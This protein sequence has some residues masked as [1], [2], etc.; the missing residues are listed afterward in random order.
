MQFRKIALASLAVAMLACSD[1]SVAPDSASTN[2]GSGKGAGGPTSAAVAT[3][4]V[5]PSSSSIVLGQT[6]Q[7]AATDADTKGNVVSGQTNVW[8]SSNAGVATVSSAGLVTA[9]AAGTATITAT[10]GSVSGS[11]TVTVA[12]AAAA[13]TPTVA[14]VT[15]APSSSSML[16]G[17]AVQ[18]AATDHD[19][20]GNVLS[21]QTNTWQSS[22]AAVAT[23][24]ATGLVTAVAA[25][26]ATI[27]ATDGAVSGSATVNVSAPATPSSSS[28]Y[29]HQ[30]AGFTLFTE[31]AFNSKAATGTDVTGA[32]GWNAN[33]EF[34]YPLFTIAQDAT[35]PKSASNVGQM[36]FPAGYSGGYSPGYAEKYFPSG[37]SK[38]YMSLW[39]KLSSN[40]YG[41][42]TYVNK[43]LYLWIGGKP[44]FVLSADGPGTSPLYPTFRIENAPD[45]TPRRLPN[46]DSTAQ[47]VRG[48]WQ[49]WEVLFIGNSAGQ[50]DGQAQ[51]W[52]DGKL[53]SDYRNIAYASGTPSWQIFQWGPTWGGIGGTVPAD[54]YIW[55]D[56]VYVSMAP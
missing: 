29:A 14:V 36:K 34:Q 30:P 9:V 39:I 43:M 8:A 18:L 50:A 37:Y 21:G 12:A 40:W 52:I 48:Q 11:A 2:R 19:Q 56:H 20:G 7:L 31:R 5:S 38:V 35:A 45:A 33:Q 49:H 27:T 53:V 15:V 3:V 54:Q 16:V 22:N 51:W 4:T 17:A 32:E 26:T 42:P 24:S 55:W 23:V 28:D 44:V 6:V 10:D 41:N 1:S 47:I 25:G 46:V 13:P